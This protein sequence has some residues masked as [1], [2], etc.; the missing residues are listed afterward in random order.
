MVRTCGPTATASAQTSRLATSAVAGIRMPARDRRSSLWG[1]C[2]STRSASMVIGCFEGMSRKYRLVPLTTEPIALHTA[3]GLTL[4][5]EL[6]VPDEP[7]AAAVLL[8]PH[9][10]HGGNM[11]S[12]VP[13]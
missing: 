3:D 12:I 7:W 9:P 8:H 5:G 1:I 6:S 11:R 10:Q 2:T 4:E 13:G